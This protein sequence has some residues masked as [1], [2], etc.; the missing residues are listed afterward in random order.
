M[1]NVRGERKGL[2]LRI[3]GSEFGL[4]AEGKEEEEG[5]GGAYPRMCSQRPRGE[6]KP[7]EV[8]IR[9]VEFGVCAKGRRERKAWR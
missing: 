9:G 3:R 1:C 8:H 7:P 6:R 2:E 5:P 4:C